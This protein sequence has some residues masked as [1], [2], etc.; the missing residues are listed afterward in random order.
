MLLMVRVIP[1][2][3]SPIP[4]LTR[5]AYAGSETLHAEQ[6]ARHYLTT[7]RERYALDTGVPIH[8]DGAVRAP[9]CR[10]LDLAEAHPGSVIVMGMYGR[11]TLGRA[12]LGSVTTATTHGATTPILVIPPH[13]PASL[14][15]TAPLKRPTAAG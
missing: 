7:V 2:L 15:R 5:G 6:E 11:G 14:T 9:A 10:I 8:L 13:A 1:N 4:G 3:T 12:A